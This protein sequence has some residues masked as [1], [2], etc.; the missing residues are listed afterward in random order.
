MQTD[1]QDVKGEDEVLE[2]GKGESEELDRGKGKGGN[3]RRYV[4]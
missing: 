4:K 3:D 1:C 2:S